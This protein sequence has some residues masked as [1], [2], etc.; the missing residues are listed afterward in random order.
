MS[1]NN[2][3]LA[4][5]IALSDCSHLLSLFL[6]DA[7]HLKI[8]GL[9]WARRNLRDTIVFDGR[10]AA[11]VSFCAD[12][13]SPNCNLDHG[14]WPA[15]NCVLRFPSR[16][17]KNQ[18]THHF[19]ADQ[20]SGH[21]HCDFTSLKFTRP[22]ARAYEILFVVLLVLPLCLVLFPLSCIPSFSS[23]QEIWSRLH[24]HL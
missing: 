24:G 11:Q 22:I 9:T 2:V 8:R 14:Q 17:T 15:Y 21:N 20:L 7:C 16:W 12:P 19:L 18:R 5:G 10:G 13:K 1:R 6:D 3:D 4:G 23:V